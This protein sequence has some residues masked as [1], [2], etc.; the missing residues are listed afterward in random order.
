ML[1]SY[2]CIIIVWEVRV[3]G[4]IRFLLGLSGVLF[5]LFRGNF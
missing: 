4:F 3:I 1:F 5:D 2:D